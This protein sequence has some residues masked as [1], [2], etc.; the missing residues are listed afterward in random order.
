[1]QPLSEDNLIGADAGILAFVKMA[2][3]HSCRL[4]IAG[5][6]ITGLVS[7]SDVQQLPVGRLCLR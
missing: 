1:M 2:D 3:R 4:V 7:L 5:S 6:E